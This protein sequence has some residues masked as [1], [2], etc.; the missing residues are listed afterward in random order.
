MQY[1]IYTQTATKKIKKEYLTDSTSFKTQNSF[2]VANK[3]N[4]QTD[5]RTVQTN[6]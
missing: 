3:A 2:A 1:N 6:R 4:Q 5:R